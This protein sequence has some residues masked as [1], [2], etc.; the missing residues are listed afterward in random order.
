MAPQIFFRTKEQ[1]AA[2]T[3]RLE[4]INE[5]FADV[6]YAAAALDG[7]GRTVTHPVEEGLVVL[8][9]RRTPKSVFALPREDTVQIEEH[10]HLR[11]RRLPGRLRGRLRLCGADAT[12][13]AR[14]VADGVDFVAARDLEKDTELTWDSTTTDWRDF[15]ALPKEAQ[16]SPLRALHLARRRE[17]IIAPHA[18]V[19]GIVKD[20]FSNAADECA[21]GDQAPL[22]GRS[23]EYAA[24]ELYWNAGG[25]YF[26]TPSFLSPFAQACA[27]GAPDAVKEQ[28]RQVDEFQR[29]F[30]VSRREGAL[31]RMSL[32][33][34]CAGAVLLKP[35][36]ADYA[37]VIAALCDAG[38]D[39]NARDV[40]GRS[41]LFCLARSPSSA[42]IEPKALDLIGKLVARGADINTVDR[43]GM[44]PL[45]APCFSDDLVTVNA[46]LELGADPHR[47]F[48]FFDATMAASL[49]QVAATIR[50][51]PR[52][53]QALRDARA[54]PVEDVPLPAEKVV[55]VVCRACG[56][57]EGK[58]R[59]CSRC[60]AAHYCSV[61]CQKY[62]WQF[63]KRTCKQFVAS[64]MPAS[65]AR[66]GPILK[67]L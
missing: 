19:R 63:H 4:T 3:E 7:R 8:R 16:A 12:L 15:S 34:V 66:D 24:A 51:A 1:H 45:F 64:G 39:P 14:V 32:H 54:H 59:K 65:L 48:L 25:D 58:F 67:G 13:L 22:K 2:V 61:A 27:A 18:A 43:A 5:A 56:T 55:V 20:C 41:P 42:A 44:N 21:D 47:S 49:S 46:L 10:E 29:A 62:D 6:E 37:A 30:L 50:M 35:D 33:A 28:L 52:I 9:Y 11:C 23:S 53:V 57:K 38:A 17:R 36:E 31:R 40:L 26:T 60:K